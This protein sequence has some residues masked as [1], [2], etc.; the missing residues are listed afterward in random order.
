M[1][2]CSINADVDG[3]REEATARFDDATLAST[4]DFLFTRLS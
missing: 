3:D 4:D 1:T 2:P